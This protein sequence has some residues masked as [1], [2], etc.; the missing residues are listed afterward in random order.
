MRD[1]TNLCQQFIDCDNI[2]GII[3]IGMHNGEELDS[4]SKLGVTNLLAFEPL[5][6][7]FAG[8]AKFSK[9]GWKFANFALGDDNKK[10]TLHVPSSHDASSSVLVPAMHLLQYPDIVFDKDIVVDQVRLDDYLRDNNLAGKYDIINIDVQGYEEHVLL[11]ATQTLQDIRY[12]LS[13]VNFDLLYQ[14]CVLVG[15]LDLLLEGF[16]FK[17]IW[18]ENS[19]LTWG[20]ALYSKDGN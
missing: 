7:C 4:Y 6:E 18:T 20:N 15:H 13:E 12:I 8:L 17:R 5:P 1:F 11:G 3:H 2:K 14:D 16:G 9:N 10:V 19:Y